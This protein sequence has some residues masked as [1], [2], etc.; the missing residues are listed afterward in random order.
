MEITNLQAGVA[1][2]LLLTVISA[3]SAVYTNT[4]GNDSDS[5]Q[6]TANTGNIKINFDNLDIVN[7]DIS[8]LKASVDKLKTEL[9]TE[10]S[11]RNSD[12]TSLK[13]RDQSLDAKINERMMPT[14]NDG[15]SGLDNFRLELSSTTIKVG[16]AFRISGIDKANTP[17]FGTLIGPESGNVLELSRQNTQSNGTFELSTFIPTSWNGGVYTL[18]VIIGQNYD[19][20]VFTVSP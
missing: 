8:D 9:D 5:N 7:G 19:R 20:I 15:P 11:A 2:M 12:V 16:D 4:Y 18:Q 3:G 1:I 14:Q 10:V 13:T 17:I 6:V